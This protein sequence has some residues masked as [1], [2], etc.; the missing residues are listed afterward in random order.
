MIELEVKPVIVLE[1]RRCYD[2][3]RW[4]AHEKGHSN[5]CQ[6]PYCTDEV[7]EAG[8]VERARLERVIRALRGA[9]TRLQRGGR[10]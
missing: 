5:R 3:G 8:R 1:T 4:W 10:A 7:V 6:C 2:C 9:I